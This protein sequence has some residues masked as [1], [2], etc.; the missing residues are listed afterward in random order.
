[1]GR[2]V[3]VEDE[4]L[5]AMYAET[6][7]LE[8]GHDVVGIAHSVKDAI[9][10]CQREQPDLVLLDINLRGGESGLDVARAMTRDIRVAFCTAENR[11]E[12][13]PGVAEVRPAGFVKKPYGK[14]DLVAQVAQLL[15]APLPT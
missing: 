5:I 15:L 8:A 1:M 7:L 3:I 4:G 2:I 6:V 12:A 9:E 13:L 14:Q 10:L 11:P